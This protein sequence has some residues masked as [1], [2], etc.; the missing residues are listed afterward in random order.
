MSFF[1]FILLSKVWPS[2]GQQIKDQGMTEVIEN[3]FRVEFQILTNPNI[4]IVGLKEGTR[5]WIRLSGKAVE[6]E[7]KTLKQA[8]LDRNP[9]LQSRFKKETEEFALFIVMQ[10]HTQFH[11]PQGTIEK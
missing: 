8:M 11:S 7:D 4:Q 2:I 6:V 10:Q 5:D 9:V 1:L 3:S